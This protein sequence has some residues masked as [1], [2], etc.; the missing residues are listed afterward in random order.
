MIL[1][2]GSNGLE[3]RVTV[4]LRDEEYRVENCLIVE[5]VSHSACLV[6]KTE[7]IVTGG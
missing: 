6:T 5:R 7:L 4:I 2:G 1:T 3:K